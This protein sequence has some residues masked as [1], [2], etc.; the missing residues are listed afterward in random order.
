M[1]W[2]A[3]PLLCAFA[4]GACSGGHHD[5]NL[6]GDKDDTH[7]YAGIAPKEVVHATGT[8]PFW[9]AT[10]KDDVLTYTT[11]DRPEGERGAVSRFAGRGG[12]SFSATLGD[13]PVTLVATEGRCVDGMSDRRYPFVI[14][15][16]IGT[17][18]RQGCGWTDRRRFSGAS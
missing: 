5:A 13:A 9:S 2:G 14:T 6:P 8:E 1:R 7:P 15:L 18:L 4:L 10:V 12:V 3:A 11:P 16:R 17:D